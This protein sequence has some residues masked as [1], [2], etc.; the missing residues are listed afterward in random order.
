MS[1]PHIVSQTVPLQVLI[2]YARIHLSFPVRSPRVT[3]RW[4]TSRPL[5][6]RT[7]AR[8]PRSSPA[9]LP[10]VPLVLVGPLPIHLGRSASRDRSIGLEPRHLACE[11]LRHFHA[12]LKG[13]ILT[14]RFCG[15]PYAGHPQNLPRHLP[16]TKSHLTCRSLPDRHVIAPPDL[17]IPIYIAPGPP[18][19]TFCPRIM[20]TIPSPLVKAGIPVR[21]TRR[22]RARATLLDC[23]EPTPIERHH[24]P[25]LSMRSAVSALLLACVRPL[26][27][28]GRNAL[29]EP[30]LVN[31][32]SA[33]LA[34]PLRTDEDY[35]VRAHASVLSVCRCGEAL[36]R[37]LPPQ[38][39]RAGEST[40]SYDPPA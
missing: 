18:R 8:G 3:S 4:S 24:S 5:T 37:C 20:E 22:A 10:T 7:R 15:M 33:V 17:P 26:L 35:C 29:A 19:A 13:G 38:D 6:P 25:F 16:L 32:Y 1:Y 36:L 39:D 28:V 34:R 2:G 11:G 31:H 27:R 21:F 14:V 40:R 23:R 9:S 30:P 12:H